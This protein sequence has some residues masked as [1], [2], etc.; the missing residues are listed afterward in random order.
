MFGRSPESWPRLRDAGAK[1]QG[2][3]A[4]VQRIASKVGER[5]ILLDVARITHFTAKDKLTFAVVNGREHAI[6]PTLNDLEQRLD[7]RRFLR[8][9]RSTILNLSFVSELYPG[10]DGMIVRLKDDRGTE[11]RVARDRVRVLKDRLGI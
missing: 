7:A 11:L 8:I 1:R 9:H 6:D 3:G 5:T 2:D 4:L 10:I